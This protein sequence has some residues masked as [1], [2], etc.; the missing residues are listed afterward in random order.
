MPQAWLFGA[1]LVLG[2]RVTVLLFPPTKWT[3]D[4]IQR[5]RTAFFRLWRWTIALLAMQG[6][7]L[8]LGNATPL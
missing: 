5:N 7:V 1:L 8:F 3:N 6:L 2:Y 4:E